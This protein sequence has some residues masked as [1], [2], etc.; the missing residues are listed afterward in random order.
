MMLCTASLADSSA[1][2]LTTFMATELLASMPNAS[3]T[4]ATAERD[5]L[6]NAL[7]EHVIARALLEGR[8]TAAERDATTTTLNAA[9][10]ITAEAAN[11][12]KKPAKYKAAESLRLGGQRAAMMKLADAQTEVNAWTDAQLK[13]G[14]FT[15]RAQ[16]F[17]ASKEEQSLAEAWQVING[18]TSASN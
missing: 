4:S 12:L 1:A 17:Q 3:R 2:L 13:A 8:I 18:D 11:V 6:R 14:K 5:K 16:A 7:S 10:D 9:A 15:T